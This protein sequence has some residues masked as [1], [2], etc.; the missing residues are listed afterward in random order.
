MTISVQ[1]DN[2]DDA[3]K[4]IMEKSQEHVAAMHNAPDDP[5][6]SMTPDQVVAMI[7]SNW[8]KS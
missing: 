5:A 1:A 6:K 7:K 2:D 3:L 4:L 8:T